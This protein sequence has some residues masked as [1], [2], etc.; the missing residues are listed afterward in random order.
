M[1]VLPEICF[2]QRF[3]EATPIGREKKEKERRREGKKDRRVREQ[4][5]TQ[6]ERERASERLYQARL[7]VEWMSSWYSAGQV[8]E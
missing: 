7:D 5:S 1:T 2:F 4:E 6:R 3:P 8:G